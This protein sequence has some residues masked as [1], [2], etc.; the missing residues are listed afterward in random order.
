M[1][2]RARVGKKGLDRVAR[3]HEGL[4]LKAGLS[5]KRF[6]IQKYPG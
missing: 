4:G 2:K 1:L 6:T 5:L 3:A